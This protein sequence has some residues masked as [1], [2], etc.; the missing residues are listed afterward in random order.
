VVREIRELK[1]LVV[2]GMEALQEMMEFQEREYEKLR[3]RFE[4]EIDEGYFQVEEDG[5]DMGSEAES[6]V[7]ERSMVGEL[8][9]LATEFEEH[10]E[11]GTEWRKVRVALSDRRE[12]EWLPLG[13][14]DVV[15]PEES[16]V[17]TELAVVEEEEQ[18]VEM[19]EIEKE[20]GE[21]RNGEL[22]GEGEE[23]GEGGETLE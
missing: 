6:D 21:E 8:K 5:S 2:E 13:S 16:E 14:D 20:K 3:E 1:T 9:G 18:D 11:R 22:D 7:L 12:F 23:D 10:L 19:G 4:E 15:P 17:V